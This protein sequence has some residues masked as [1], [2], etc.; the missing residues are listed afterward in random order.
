[1]LC[2]LTTHKQKKL[3]FLNV[4]QTHWCEGS[5]DWKSSVPW[6]RCHASMYIHACM[7]VQIWLANIIIYRPSWL[8]AWVGFGPS[9]PIPICFQKHILLI[10]FIMGHFESGIKAKLK[11]NSQTTNSI[12]PA[13]TAIAVVRMRILISM[14]GVWIRI[15]SGTT[16]IWIRFLL[17]MTVVQ[18]ATS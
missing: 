17:G 8:N 9:T 15:L 1:M 13:N 7:Y 5:R 2:H 18:I 6:S 3:G 14:T 16:V 11:W 10:I 12:N 4:A